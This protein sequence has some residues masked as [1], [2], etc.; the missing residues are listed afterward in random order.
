MTQPHGGPGPDGPGFRPCYRH[1]DRQTGI[2]CQRCGRPICGQCMVQA[3]VGFQCPDCVAEGRASQRPVRTRSRTRAL[4]SQSA[5]VVLIGLIV[6]VAAVD[7]V[8]LGGVQGLLAYQGA[9]VLSGQV[10][11]L[12]THTLV[13]GGIL[14]LLINGFVLWIF[15]RTMESMWGKWRFLATFLLSGLGAAT[16]LL[17]AG[18]LGAVLGG[19]SSAI[20]GLLAANAGSKIRAKEDARPDFVLLAI[21]VAFSI[22]TYPAMVL[23]DVGSILAGGAAGWL[24]ASSPRTGSSRP[25]GRM[26]RTDRWHLTGALVILAVCLVLVGVAFVIR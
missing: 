25:G 7:S 6:A 18:P 10:W 5:T 1:P 21:L 23:A 8:A 2:S 4:A 17:V 26:A 14:G 19:G 24:W 13:S 16:A 22:F 12:L 20:I 3:S 15:G 9:A 11:R